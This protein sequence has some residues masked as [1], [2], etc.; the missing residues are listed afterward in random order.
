MD[1][2]YVYDMFAVFDRITIYK[3]VILKSIIVTEQKSLQRKLNVIKKSANASHSVDTGHIFNNK[4]LGLLKQI[5][6]T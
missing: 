6:K 1:K 2:I 5:I 4:S 3:I